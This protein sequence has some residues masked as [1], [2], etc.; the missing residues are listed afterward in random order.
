MPRPKARGPGNLVR[1]L[2]VE[3]LLEDLA[4][5]RRDLKVDAVAILTGPRNWTHMRRDP[6]FA[7]HSQFWPG[8][9]ETFAGVSV[10]ISRWADVPRVM[11]TQQDLEA[12][13]LGRES[14]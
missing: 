11:A 9:E 8:D 4:D 1:T 5:V 13:L 12:A 2:P 6:D 7:R 14:E 10:V 3:Q